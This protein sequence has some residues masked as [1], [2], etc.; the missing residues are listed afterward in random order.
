[1][2][3]VRSSFS[4]NLDPAYS[5]CDK[6]LPCREAHCAEAD[7]FIFFGSWYTMR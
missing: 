7:Y 1:M 2:K 5:R 3:K 6:L 4:L